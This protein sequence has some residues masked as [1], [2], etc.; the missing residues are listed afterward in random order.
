MING[1]ISTS[2]DPATTVWQHLSH[3]FYVSS[4][5]QYYSALPFNIT[6]GVNSLQGTAGRPLADGTVST[7]NFDVR[8]VNFIPRN[9]GVG[10]D[11]FTMSLRISR[12]FQLGGGRRIEGCGVIQSLTKGAA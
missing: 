4:M 11:L 12:A 9:A 7:A 1:T 5:L 10:N 8:G 3:G 6:S 2:T